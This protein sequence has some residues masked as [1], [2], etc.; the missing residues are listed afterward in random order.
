M[1]HFCFTVDDNIRFLRELTEGDYGCIFDHPYL[2]MYKRMHEKYGVLIQLNLFYEAEDFDL[3][4]VT[5]RYSSEWLACSDWLKLSFH[6]RL[7]NVRPYELSDGGE[8]FSDCRAVHN[9]IL[10]FA[11]ERSLAKTT[12]VHYCLATEDGI[13]A[14][15]QNGV[16]GLLGLYGDADAPRTSYRS[17]PEEC[18]RIR[19]GEVVCR[20]GMSYAAI[21]IVLN[22]CS[23]E[24]ILRRLRCLSGR[25]R[26]GIMIHEQYFYPDYRKYQVDFE[27]KLDAA[28]AYLTD[29]GYKSVFFENETE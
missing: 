8:V 24:E 26:I 19:S 12:T 15:Y 27:E 14:L 20:G 2:A 29:N 13:S 9:E 17:T 7:E 22:T 10:R 28:F 25:E 21:D 3:S 4:Q 1:K 16:K 5:D 11:S 23:K 18:E 6:S